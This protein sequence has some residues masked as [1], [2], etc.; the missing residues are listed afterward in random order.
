M[1]AISW[2][3]FC[4]FS[5]PSMGIFILFVLFTAGTPIKTLSQ[6]I[7]GY[8]LDKETREPLIGASVYFDNTTIGTSTD[9]DGYF[10][11]TPTEGIRSSMIISFI[12]YAPEVRGQSSSSGNL[13]IYLE[14]EENVLEEVILSPD[15]DWPRE[16]KL[17]EFK[18]HYLGT[19]I[20]GRTCVILNEDDLDL[21]YSKKRKRLY[22]RARAPLQIENEKLRYRITADLRAFGLGYSSVSRNKKNLVSTGVIYKGL[23]RY[24]DLNG[25]GSP[26]VQQAR[27]EAYYG[28]VL[29]FMRALSE[30]RLFEEGY[31]I[32]YQGKFIEPNQMFTVTEQ[33]GG[34]GTV[35]RLKD[36]V[37]I[38]YRATE[39]S[40]ME[41]TV[42]EFYID[43]Q[44]NHSPLDKVRFGG[45]MGDQRMGDALP[46][47][48][49][50]RGESGN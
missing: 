2:Y 31:K 48:F 1:A 13:R 50:I 4:Q 44:G 5:K 23:N 49:L 25:S 29:H 17:S 16:L 8:V 18:K 26:E 41:V 35:V 37:E 21:V 47:D 30:G 24:E 34:A 9:L 12:G 42:K 27:M 36:K 3:D 28:S 33:A 45:V 10:E 7:S 43:R 22:A 20:R 38:L 6:T 39:L 19:S 14:P 46:M 32:R 15:D 40:A 11:I